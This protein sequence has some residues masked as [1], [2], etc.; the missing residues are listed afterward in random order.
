L[1]SYHGIGRLFV[2]CFNL[3]RQKKKAGSGRAKKIK[4]KNNNNCFVFLN[5]KA[6]SN[7][8]KKTIKTWQAKKKCVC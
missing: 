8:S 7:K 2:L 6:D 3:K 1:G 5:K 4:K